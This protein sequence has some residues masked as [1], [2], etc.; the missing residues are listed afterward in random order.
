MVG[1]RCI[2]NCKVGVYLDIMGWRQQ[3]K[4][5][6]DALSLI[7]SARA[8][9]C[10]TA[11]ATLHHCP[12][13][14]TT[15]LHHRSRLR[16]QCHRPKTGAWAF[17]CWARQRPRMLD[18]VIRPPSA[19]HP[20]HHPPS[21][22]PPSTLPIALHPTHPPSTL[23]TAL[24]PTH[25]PPSYPSALHP[26]HRVPPDWQRWRPISAGRIAPQRRRL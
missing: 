9:D 22:Q 18:P 14:R 19:L 17:A 8:S 13:G 12:H 10:T 4:R 26:T 16:H 3:K 6:D 23:P 2:R 21:Y 11:R 5:D 15:A 24:H 25:R 7:H 1:E 20:T